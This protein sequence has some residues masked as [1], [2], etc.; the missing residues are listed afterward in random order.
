MSP[1]DA[2]VLDLFPL[3]NLPGAG[4]NYL[5]QPVGS[6]A[7]TQF[8]ARVD[9]RLT[10]A[11]EPTLRYSWGKHDLFEPYTQSGSGLPGFGD[12]VHDRGHN[13]MIHHTH[14]FG[15]RAINSLILGYNRAIRQVLQQNHQTDVNKLWSV[16][17][18]LK[19][20]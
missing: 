10:P 4:G 11:D 18:L 14:S 7:E 8:N 20:P 5:G 2:Q 9:H 6:S 15:S 3:P 13:A 12:D 16:D 17:Y 19:F 1:L